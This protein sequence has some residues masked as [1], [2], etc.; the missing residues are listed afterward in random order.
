M[1][2][3]EENKRLKS[4]IMKPLYVAN[5]CENPLS[6]K[7]EMEIGNCRSHH[8]YGASFSKI[9]MKCET[10]SHLVPYHPQMPLKDLKRRKK[11]NS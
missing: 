7:L 5:D 8:I 4:Y 9:L 3:L 10:A 11:E 6:L 2:G 1:Q